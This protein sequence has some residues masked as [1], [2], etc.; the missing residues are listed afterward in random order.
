MVLATAPPL[1]SRECLLPLTDCK[2][3]VS[4]HNGSWW[5]QVDVA[6]VASSPLRSPTL[7]ALSAVC[8]APGIPIRGED[9]SGRLLHSRMPGTL[10]YFRM[11]T[12]VALTVPLPC[13]GAVV[14]MGRTGH[15]PK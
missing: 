12:A 2:V 15:R 10:V 11:L 4:V 5:A 8:L 7:L 6:W 9:S 3:K 1:L 14:T 13:G